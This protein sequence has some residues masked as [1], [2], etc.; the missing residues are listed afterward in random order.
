MTHWMR[1]VTPNENRYSG[2][3]SNSA[4]SQG[5]SRAAP[6]SSLW[7]RRPAAE[8]RRA[9]TAA[10]PVQDRAVFVH[11]EA[12]CSLR[13]LAAVVARASVGGACGRAFDGFVTRRLGR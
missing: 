1:Q 12:W 11:A 10:G 9:T 6:T 3:N 7:S 5:R 13:V 8:P 4:G 2:G